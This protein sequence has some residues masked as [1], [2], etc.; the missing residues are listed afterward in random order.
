MEYTFDGQPIVVA[1]CPMDR[2]YSFSCVRRP[3]AQCVFDAGGPQVD[4]TEW[5]VDPPVAESMWI[6]LARL[7]RLVDKQLAKRRKRRLGRFD[8]WAGRHPLLT[9][10][11]CVVVLTVAILALGPADER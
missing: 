3:C 6:P 2:R 7:F 11:A 5:V 4:A 8:Q 10:V 1:R 9:F